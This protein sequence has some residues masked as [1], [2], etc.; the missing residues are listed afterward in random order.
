M[1]R[2]LRRR[3][4]RAALGLALV[5]PAA[6][7]AALAARAPQ[8][9][10]AGSLAH[11]LGEP[12]SA[13]AAERVTLAPRVTIAKDPEGRRVVELDTRGLETQPDALVYWSASPAT[14]ESL[15]PDAFF[16][17]ALP[18]SAVRAYRLPEPARAGGGSVF[19]FSVAWQRL[20]L[21]QSLGA[22]A[23]R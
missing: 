12:S 1:I 4:R 8:P 14:G 17:G 10:V 19:V 3:H 21:A 11:S 23:A 9:V 20:L 5:L 15:P 18:E 6:Y 13:A 2:E 7:V 22:E 16:L